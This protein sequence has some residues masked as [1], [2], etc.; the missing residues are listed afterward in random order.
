MVKTPKDAH[1]CCG[2]AGT[3]NLLQ[4]EISQKLQHS[5]VTYLQALEPDFIAAGNIGCLVQ[6][7][8]KSQKSVVHTLE[9]LD[10]AY[11]GIEPESLM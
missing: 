5:K 7:G 11:G 3:Y 2:S 9:L 8:Q 6:I 10:W 4:P 1:L